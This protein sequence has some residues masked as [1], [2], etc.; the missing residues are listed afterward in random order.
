LAQNEG[1]LV[2]LSRLKIE[3]DLKGGTRVTAR[4][5]ISRK[6]NALQRSG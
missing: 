5:H 1:E 4:F 6:A 3:V 2:L